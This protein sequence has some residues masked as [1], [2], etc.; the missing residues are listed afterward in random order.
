[1]KVGEMTGTKAFA[2][3]MLMVYFGFLALFSTSYFIQE[4]LS[5]SMTG[6]LML[7]E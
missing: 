3:G 7:A 1:V 4:L 5:G 6:Q 2:I